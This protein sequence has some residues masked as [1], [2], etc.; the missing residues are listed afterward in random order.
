LLALSAAP[1][2]C[3]GLA[4]DGDDAAEETIDKDTSAIVS[5]PVKGTLQTLDIDRIAGKAGDR[6]RLL[7][8]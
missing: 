8:Q 5:V 2:S 6:R 3:G 1:L 4:E 7:A